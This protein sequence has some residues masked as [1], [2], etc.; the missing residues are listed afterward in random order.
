MHEL[1]IDLN[2]C[3]MQ[4]EFKAYM[5][6]VSGTRMI[7][8]DAKQALLIDRPLRDLIPIDESALERWSRLKDWL[9]I[10]AWKFSRLLAPRQM[11]CRRASY[12]I[13]QLFFVS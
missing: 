4:Y 6:H 1:V 13:R 12:S 5:I 3:Q 2:S 9:K 7:K 11:V 8:Q 10:L